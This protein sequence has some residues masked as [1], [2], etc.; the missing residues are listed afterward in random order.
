[1]KYH[2]LFALL[3]A[4]LLL[5]NAGCCYG[6]PQAGGSAVVAPGPIVG[7]DC[8]KSA[9]WPCKSGQ[10]LSF[11]FICDGRKDCIDGYDEDKALCI[12]KDRP[13]SI[14]LKHFI[15]RFHD[16]LIPKILGNGTPDQIAKLL[17]E[18]RNVA[19]YAQKMNLTETQKETLVRVMEFAREGR[20]LDLVY[21]NMPEDAYRETYALF[22][23]IVESGFLGSEGMRNPAQNQIERI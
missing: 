21:E 9:P 8:P 1:M 12:A 7:N 6:M 4:V 14:I 16:W 15:M 20:V 2:P 18:E 13:A 23:R 19:D 11:A 17:T 10:C 5:G 3:P 22:G